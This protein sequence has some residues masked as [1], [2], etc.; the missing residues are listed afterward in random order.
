[1]YIILF[2]IPTII[3]VENVKKTEIPI[4]ISNKQNIFKT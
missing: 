4:L 3:C 2:N 1:M